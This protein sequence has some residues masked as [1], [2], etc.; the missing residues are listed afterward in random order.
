MDKSILDS[1]QA[2]DEMFDILKG[3]TSRF[4]L[5]NGQ[6]QTHGHTQIN[7]Y[8]PLHCRCC[9]IIKKQQKKTN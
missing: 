9:G 1:Q 5:K 7:C 3:L 4:G 2:K 8:M 6:T